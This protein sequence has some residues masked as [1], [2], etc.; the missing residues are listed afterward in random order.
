[1]YFVAV[2]HRHSQTKHTW[3]RSLQIEFFILTG[4]CESVSALTHFKT[5]THTPRN[6]NKQERLRISVAGNKAALQSNSRRQRSAESRG[7]PWCGL[8]CTSATRIITRPPKTRENNLIGVQF[9]LFF[10]KWHGAAINYTHWIYLLQQTNLCTLNKITIFSPFFFIV[11]VN[12]SYC[13][14]DNCVLFWLYVAIAV[15]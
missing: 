12:A 6:T 13:W 14:R 4:K 3:N 2:H 9:G 10:P 5:H 8:P 7:S 15:V 1:M 11:A